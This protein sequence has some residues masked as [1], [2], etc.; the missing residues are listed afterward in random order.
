MELH[1][2]SV[3]QAAEGIRKREV[4]PVELVEALLRRI[5]SLEP[6]LKAWVAVD[7]EGALAAA[8]QREQEAGGARP[9]GPLH[10][11]PIGVKDIFHAEGFPTTCGSPIFQDRMAPYDATSVAR[12]RQAGAVVLGKTV[13]VQFA[14][15]DPPPTRNP[16]N[17]D[18]TPGGSSSGTAAAVAS[19]MVAAGLGSQ[20]GGSILRPAA[21]CGT[22]GLKPT[23]GRISRF[24]VAPASWS[25][26]HIGHLTRSVE[27]AALLLQVMAGHD[28]KDQASSPAAVG[29]YP[30]AARRMDS[31]PRL[32][33]VLDEE[34]LATPEVADHLRQ[35]ARR[36]ERAGAEVRQVSFPVPMSEIQAVRSL[37]CEVEASA[38]HTPLHR[39]HAEL[40]GPEIRAVVEVGQLLPSALYIQAQRL[41]RKWRPQVERMLEGVDCLLMPAVHNVAPDPSTTG[42]SMFQAPWS[43]FGQPA[44][45]LP[46]GLSREGLPLAIQLVA[47][48]FH[49]EELLSAAA[50]CE[51][52]LGPMPSPC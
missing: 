3:V 40:Y 14:H 16:W 24:G 8:K 26:D 29:D 1:E 5:D 36:F 2:L 45:S 7:R 46:S 35:I 19:R 10:G 12:L 47:P 49:E 42:S 28:P 11:V 25:L 9:V 6:D 22:V 38:V 48:H 33:F 39:E 18:R 32:G 21:Y 31:A 23:Y 41:R 51:A 20:T 4:S 27:D 15:F 43:L 13:T 50:W 52:V 17:H 44:I 34:R 37:V 30:R